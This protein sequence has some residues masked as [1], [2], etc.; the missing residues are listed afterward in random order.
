MIGLC[1]TLL[2]SLHKQNTIKQGQLEEC[3]GDDLET[4]VFWVTVTEV[5][6]PTSLN[7]YIMTCTSAEQQLLTHVIISYTYRGLPAR[8]CS[9]FWRLH[10]PTSSLLTSAN[11]S[12]T[13]N[14]WVKYTCG[15]NLR[16]P[17]V[18]GMWGGDRWGDHYKAVTRVIQRTWFTIFCATFLSMVLTVSG[19]PPKCVCISYCIS[20]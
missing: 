3:I 13:P 12:L 18:L 11:T 16:N 8:Y 7:S 14:G 20:F 4:R 2:A 17:A 15:L 9:C 19:I 5:H 10:P 1:S 6:K